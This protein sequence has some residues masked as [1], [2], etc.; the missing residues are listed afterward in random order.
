MMIVWVPVVIVG[1][2][3][4]LAAGIGLEG[5]PAVWRNREGIIMYFIGTMLV[6]GG[7][8]IWVQNSQ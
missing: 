1:L 3:L 7:I 5:K 8:Q 2:S 6:S 4:M